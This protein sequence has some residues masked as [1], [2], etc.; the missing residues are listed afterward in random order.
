MFASEYLV[1]RHYG[2]P[3]EGGWWYDWSDFKAVVFEGSDEEA[4]RVCKKRN[5]ETEPQ[6]F[7]V[8]AGTYPDRVYLAEDYPGEHQSKHRPHYE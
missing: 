3:E 1:S 2:G 8:A 5:A 4:I 7:S 6:R